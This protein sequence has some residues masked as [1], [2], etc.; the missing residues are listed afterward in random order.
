MFVE[1]KIP[2][3]VHASTSKYIDNT[4]NIP[5]NSMLIAAAKCAFFPLGPIKIKVNNHHV[6][7]G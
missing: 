1:E 6:L 2:Y 7:K 3:Q 4:K 5:M